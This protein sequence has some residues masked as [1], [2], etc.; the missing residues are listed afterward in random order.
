MMIYFFDENSG[1][2]TCSGNEI[3]ILCVNIN[4]NPDDVNSYED[5]PKTIIHVRL[6]A[7]H[8][9]LQ[10]HKA[11]KKEIR[12]INAC[13]MVSNKM[14]GLVHVRRWGK[15]IEPVYWKAAWTLLNF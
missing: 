3:G 1:N 9:K 8:N 2:V 4:I 5:D 11:F 12:K 6:F 14:V 13:S 10:Q 15:K 7:S